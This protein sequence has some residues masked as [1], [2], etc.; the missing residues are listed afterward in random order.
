MSYTG[1]T[2]RDAEAAGPNQFMRVLA[3]RGR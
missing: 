3:N 2:I 1:T